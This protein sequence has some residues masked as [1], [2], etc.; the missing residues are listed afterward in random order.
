MTLSGNCHYCSPS[1]Y[2]SDGDVD[3]DDG[4]PVTDGRTSDAIPSDADGDGSDDD[5]GVG[6][7]TTLDAFSGS[8][9]LMRTLWVHNSW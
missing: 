1:Q 8:W 6:A 2:S 4:H 5:H 7:W 3:A 9:A